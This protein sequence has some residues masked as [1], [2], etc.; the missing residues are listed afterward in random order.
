MSNDDDEVAHQ[1][2]LA[3]LALRQPMPRLLKAAYEGALR[4][5]LDLGEG[6]SRR[7]HDLRRLISGC[8]EAEGE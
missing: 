8:E 4:D 7:A 2:R 3:E 1:R 6:D 5:L